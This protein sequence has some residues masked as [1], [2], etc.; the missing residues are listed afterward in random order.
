MA[1]IISQEIFHKLAYI[2]KEIVWISISSPFCDHTIYILFNLADL[3]D[4][5][6]TSD[7]KM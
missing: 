5:L 2:L 4:V 3:L 6:G 7:L 1:S